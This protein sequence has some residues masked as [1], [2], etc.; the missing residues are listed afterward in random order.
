VNCRTPG[1][2]MRPIPTRG[3]EGMSQFH[4]Y[5]NDVEVPAENLVGPENQ[6]ARAIFNSLNPERILASATAIG[7]SDYLVQRAVAYAKDRKVF[8]DQ[9]IGAYQSIQHPLAEIAIQ[10]EAA[11]LMTYR[12]A[13]SFDR[14]DDPAKVGTWAN[15]AKYLAAEN[16][17]RA[18]DQA[19]QTLGGYGFSEEYGVIYY[20]ETLRLLRTAP[21]TK[22]MI[23]NYVAQYVLDLPRSY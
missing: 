9:P 20:W 21:I 10:T 17:I 3:I 6:G 5:F 2:E 1:I 22:E 18:A 16:A 4:I 12:A 7:M 23:L 11:R 14:D 8:R 19:I 13:W 15:M